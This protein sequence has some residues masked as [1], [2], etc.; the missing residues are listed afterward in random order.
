MS[1]TSFVL[2]VAA[3]GQCPHVVPDEPYVRSD[4]DACSE[5]PREQCLYWTRPS[6]LWQQSRAGLGEFAAPGSGEL[7]AV[8]RAFAS[9]QAIFSECGNLDLREGPPSDVRTTGYS[10]GRADNLNLVLFRTRSCAQVVP[11]SDACWAEGRC[12]NQYDCWSYD[13]DTIAITLTTYDEESGVVYDS[14]IEL[15]AAPQRDGRRFV[16]SSTETPSCGAVGPGQCVLTDVQNTVTHEVGHLLGLDHTSAAG[17]TMNPTAAP[18]DTTKRA[19][20]PGSRSFVCSVYPRGAPSQAC[21]N[22]P[23]SD[24]LGRSSGSCS[25]AGLGPAAGIWGLLVA[26]GPFL[27]RRGAR[28]RP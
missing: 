4:V 8:R 1:L 12:S 3:L 19:V 10:P 26:A 27:A 15:N 5:S 2:V 21:V 22:L 7:D 16:F 9:W 13:E 6:I 14:D 17:S 24:E 28:R 23:A 20:D 11:S 18:G 25:G